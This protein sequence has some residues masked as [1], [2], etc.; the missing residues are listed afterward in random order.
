VSSSTP[1]GAKSISANKYARVIE[2]VTGVTQYGRGCIMLDIEGPLVTEKEIRGF[3]LEP[4][5]S[6]NPK[7]SYIKGVVG[8]KNAHVTLLYGLLDTGEDWKEAVDAVLE[9]WITPLT[10]QIDEISTFPSTNEGEDYTVLIG[11]VQ[12]TDDLLE[13]RA[14]LS[15]LPHINTF[16]DYSPHVTLAYIKGKEE[17]VRASEAFKEAQIFLLSETELNVIGL[18]YGR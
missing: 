3:G 13:G 5:F 7:L 1:T 18:N 2:R 4:Y 9:E 15:F 14:L 16:T 10:I 11:K 6:E 17:D 8:E 12:V